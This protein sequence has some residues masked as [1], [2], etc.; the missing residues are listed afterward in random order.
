[1]NLNSLKKLSGDAS[2]RN[3]Y[4]NKNSILVYCKK[5]KKSNLLIYDAVNKILLKNKI[6][7]PKLLSE[8]YYKNY[9]EI[10]DFGDLTV[11]KNFK[12]KKLIKFIITKKF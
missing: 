9:M 1:M 5:E 2:F 6:L 7:A 4:R 11:L 3:F 10:E 12:K 8:N